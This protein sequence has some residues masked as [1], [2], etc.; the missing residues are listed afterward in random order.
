VVKSAH[1]KLRPG[2]CRSTQYLV[3]FL[4]AVT[5]IQH[6]QLTATAPR[7]RPYSG[8]HR[9]RPERGSHDRRGASSVPRRVATAMHEQLRA[10]GHD[11]LP[12]HSEFVRLHADGLLSDPA[13]VA[14][15]I[16]SLLDDQDVTPGQVLNLAVNR[17]A[18][19]DNRAGTDGTNQE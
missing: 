14:R 11:R 18:A 15:Q 4:S 6:H 10:A 9:T 2:A 12:D 8:P 19:D 7:I 13:D 1:S 3:L 5:D 17:P 16:W